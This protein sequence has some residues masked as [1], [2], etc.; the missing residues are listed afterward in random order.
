MQLLVQVS[1]TAS[2]V[3]KEATA[4]NSRNARIAEIHRRAFP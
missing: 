1:A 4:V 2:A 3:M